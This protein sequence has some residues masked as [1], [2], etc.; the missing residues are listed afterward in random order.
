MSIYSDYAKGRMT[1]RKMEKIVA[2]LAYIEKNPGTS[3]S[4]CIESVYGMK[5]DYG[6]AL[7]AK[8]NNDG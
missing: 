5:S 7:L 6:Y 8:L 3:R 2:I 4:H 1:P